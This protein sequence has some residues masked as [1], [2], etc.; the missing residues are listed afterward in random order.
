VGPAEIRE[1]YAAD[2]P[3]GRVGRP[4]EVAAVVAHLCSEEAGTITGQVVP[5][6]GGAL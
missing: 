2:V 4:E 6:A 3:L 5:I 1:R